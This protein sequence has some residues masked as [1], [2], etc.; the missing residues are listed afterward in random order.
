MSFTKTRTRSN[1]PN[2]SKPFNSWQKIQ[3]F[4]ISLLGGALVWLIGLTLRYRLEDW[5]NFQQ[6]KEKRKSVIYSFWHNQIFYATHFWRF[7]NILVVTSR[8]FDGEY[9]ARVI[10]KFGYVAARGSTGKG[11]AIALLKL[12]R[13]LDQGIDTAFTIDGPQGPIYKVKPGPIWLSR[14]MGAPIVPFHIQPKSFWTLSSW[15]Q[16][17]IPRPFT[18]VLV[19]IGQPLIVPPDGDEEAWMIRYQREMDRI[20]EYCESYW[21][22]QESGARSQESG[23]RSQESGVRS[24][25]SGVRIQNP[26]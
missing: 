21:R 7:R 23:V 5:E 16:F 8:H 3:I 12:K 24:Q 6:F 4:L 9:I 25:E 10:E 17:R 22:S 1:N 11:G 13:C 19:K 2:T 18:P 26:E 20:R 14:N 15:D